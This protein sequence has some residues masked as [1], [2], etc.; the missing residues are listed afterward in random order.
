MLALLHRWSRHDYL[1]WLEIFIALH[2]DNAHW[3][4]TVEMTTATYGVRPKRGVRLTYICDVD[5]FGDFS[6]T[7]S[8]ILPDGI[9]LQSV[10]IATLK[11]KL[12]D[13]IK[14]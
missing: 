3:R 2:S 1:I 4:S 10:P 8:Y 9:V 11:K 5:Q 6:I 14:R 7:A 12:A 13:T